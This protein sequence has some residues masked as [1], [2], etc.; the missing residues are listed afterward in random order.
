MSFWQ[1]SM[2]SHRSSGRELGGGA[3][4]EHLLLEQIARGDIDNDLGFADEIGLQDGEFFV[5]GF[6]LAQRGIDQQRLTHDRRRLGQSHGRD[7]LQLQFAD[8]G[9]VVKGVAQFV[10]HGA[11]LIQRAVEIAQDA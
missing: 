5:G 4:L 1:R 8:L 6:G 7:G 2:I 3:P 11:D 10:G 9:G